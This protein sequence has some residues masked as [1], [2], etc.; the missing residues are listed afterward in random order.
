MTFAKVDPVHEGPPAQ[1]GSRGGRIRLA[2]SPV[3]RGAALVALGTLALAA[4][5]W[6]EVPM[7]PVP[8]TMQTFVVVLL[9]A[10]Y[11]WRL[12]TLTVL[13]YLAQA[14]LGL[15]VLAGGKG[16]LQAFAG[17]TAG[18]LFAFPVG[19]ALVGVLSERGWTRRSLA[20][21]LGAMVLAHALIFAGGL[22]WLAAVA[23][24]G[25]E[26]AVAVGL[27]PFVLGTLLKSALATACERAA[28]LAGWAPH[29]AGR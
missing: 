24:L 17:P 29:G 27:A 10:L 22:A 19:A 13:A 9:G 14:A 16:G 21:S 26:R 18:Y 15:P 8:M 23:G 28:L 5:A 1:A 12:A 3:L 25:W 2:A 20:L 4:G 11:G 7:V 6:A